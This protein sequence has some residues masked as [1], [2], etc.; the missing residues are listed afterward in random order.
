MIPAT[1]QPFAVFLCTMGV[2][3]M[4][5]LIRYSGLT[6]Y[7]HTAVDDKRADVIA[8]KW[9]LMTPVLFLGMCG[10]FVPF[11]TGRYVPIEPFTVGLGVLAIVLS[12]VGDWIVR[13]FFLKAQ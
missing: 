6:A 7:P 8:R 12:P 11:L 5:D 10:L 3:M 4:V 13:R 2:F 9:G 1:L